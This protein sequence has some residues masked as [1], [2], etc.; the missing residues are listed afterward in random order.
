MDRR[1]STLYHL[2]LKIF[3]S[4]S[5][6][7]SLKIKCILKI[8][9]CKIMNVLKKVNPL[10]GIHALSGGRKQWICELSLIHGCWDCGFVFFFFFLPNTLYF[11][12][13]Y[14]DPYRNK[15]HLRKEGSVKP[16][17]FIAMSVCINS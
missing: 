2:E 14:K 16:C 7:P 11:L 5:S 4:V 17:P 15:I 6:L 8:Q 13:F 9:N 3:N 10:G 1:V 12:I